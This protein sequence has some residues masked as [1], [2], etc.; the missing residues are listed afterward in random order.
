MSDIVQPLL[1]AFRQIIREEIHNVQHKEERWITTEELMAYLGVSRSWISHRIKEIPH[2]SS[3]QR[4]K[5]SEVDEWLKSMT[6]DI[7]PQK[8]K[9]GNSSKKNS[10][11]VI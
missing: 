2:I 5:K 11:K 8:I 9:V 1:D 7:K 4:F 10:L 3:P 6:E